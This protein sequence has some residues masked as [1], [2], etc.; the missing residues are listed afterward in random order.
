MGHIGPQMLYNPLSTDQVPRTAPDV[1]DMYGAE[2]WDVDYAHGKRTY[3]FVKVASTS[4]DLAAGDV[5]CFTD[6]YATTVSNKQADAGTNARNKVAGVAIGKIT[7]GHCGYIQTYG[8]HAGV[9]DD[10]GTYA[11]GL[12]TILSAS[13]TE[14]APLT[15][16]TAPT[17]T[18][19]G[20]ALGASSAGK[21]PSFL[22]VG[23]MAP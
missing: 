7:A 3:K 1:Q 21:H 6:H 4:N 22:H 20:T 2:W 15:L 17:H 9:K 19:V 12:L 23:R 11:D 10:G 16:G 14:T 8:Y 18:V 5:V 13:D